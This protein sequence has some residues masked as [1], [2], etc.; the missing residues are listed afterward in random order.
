MIRYRGDSFWAW[1]NPNMHTRTHCE[2]LADGSQI[3]VQVRLSKVGATQLFLGVYGPD[4]AMLH[5]EAFDNRPGE[6][7]TRAMAWGVGRARNLA[8]DLAASRTHPRAQSQ[9]G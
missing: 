2:T 5:E 1:A 7:M 9:T 4:G 8:A 6:T 3:D